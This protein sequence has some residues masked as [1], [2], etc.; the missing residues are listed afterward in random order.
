MNVFRRRSL[1][2]GLALVVAMA[3]PAP[4][5]AQDREPLVRAFDALGRGAQIGVTVTDGES[6]D[7]KQPKAGVVVETVNPGGPADKAGVKA[8]DTITEFDGE[9]VRSVVQFSRLVRETAP[10]SSVPAALSRGGQKVNVT[11]TPEH[12]SM[13]DDFTFRY[14]DIP[15]V[16]PTPRPPSPPAVPRAVRPFDD[17]ALTLLRGFGSG[18][19]LGIT[20]ESIDDQFA[21]YFGVKE[22]ALV[23][24]VLDGSVAQK[25]GLKAGDVITAINGTKVYDTSDLNRAMERLEANGDFTI[26][27]MRDKK[28]QTLKGKLEARDT[29]ARTRVRTIL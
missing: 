5:A 29:R 19:R 18:R 3:A 13:S 6:N 1:A 16:A 2:G 22:G 17:G 25:A 11:I 14:M 10:G 27:I 9:R 8:G 4:A 24:S 7:S 23:K 15:R 28:P 21:E 26:E 20:I 12:R